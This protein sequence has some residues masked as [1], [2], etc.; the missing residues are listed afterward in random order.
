MIQVISTEKRIYNH[1]HIEDVFRLCEVL[2]CHGYS[3]DLED[4]EDLWNDYSDMRAAGWLGMP[5][6]DEEL[7]QCVCD[8][9]ERKCVR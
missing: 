2:K 4:C 6:D 8:D 7:W 3:A 9:V 1:R 5:D